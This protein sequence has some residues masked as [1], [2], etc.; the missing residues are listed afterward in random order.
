MVNECHATENKKHCWHSD[1]IMLLSYPPKIEMV[2]CYCGQTT[3]FR[4]EVTKK[5]THGQYDPSKRAL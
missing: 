2:C 4:L 1:G 3:F 5:G